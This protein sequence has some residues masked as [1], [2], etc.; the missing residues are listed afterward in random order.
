MP[1]LARQHG[2]ADVV[3][4]L[5]Q[6][7][8]ADVVGLLP[9]LDEAAATVDVVVGQRLLDLR[10]VQAVGNQFVGID[11]HLVLAR[12]PAKNRHRRD[13]RH[14]H[15]V[16]EHHPVLQRLEVHDVVARIGALQSVEVDLAGGTEVGTDL[17]IQ[18]RRQD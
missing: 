10:H 3:G 12:L 18:A 13:V 8:G 1:F 17:R 16:L 14:R 15:Q 7:D 2:G 9:F 4:V 6:A 5:H 11:L